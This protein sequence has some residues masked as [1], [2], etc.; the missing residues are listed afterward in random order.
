MVRALLVKNYY[1]TLRK[2]IW[3]ILLILCTWFSSFSIHLEAHQNNLNINLWKRTEAG[4]GAWAMK[5]ESSGAGV[6]LMKPKGSGVGAMFMKRTS[7]EP[8]LCPFY[9]GSTV[10]K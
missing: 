10:L 1:Y 8:E 9:N 7:P 4:D 2:K 5:K 6:T 3:Y